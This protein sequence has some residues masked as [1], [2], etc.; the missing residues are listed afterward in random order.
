MDSQI[1]SEDPCGTLLAYCPSSWQWAPKGQT[2]LCA[3]PSSLG[4]S[5]RRAKSSPSALA[6]LPRGKTRPPFAFLDTVTVSRPPA[7]TESVQQI[8]KRQVDARAV[9]FRRG[10][11][12]HRRRG[13]PERYALAAYRTATAKN[14][15][16]K[17]FPPARSSTAPPAIAS[18]WARKAHGLSTEALLLAFLGRLLSGRLLSGRALRCG[19][20][21]CRHRTPPRG[22]SSYYTT[23]MDMTQPYYNIWVSAG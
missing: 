7:V 9:L 10:R 23:F 13:A 16:R 20:A 8:E 12:P 17:D 2:L 18:I 1:S 4:L 11:S 22:I 3:G 15:R 19:L 5:G 6:F 14:R 21:G